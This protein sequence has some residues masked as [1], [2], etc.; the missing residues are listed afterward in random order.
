M[1]L[2]ASSSLISIITIL[3][4]ITISAQAF[5]PSQTTTIQPTT[6]TLSA[7]PTTTTATSGTSK[8]AHIS[9]TTTTNL[10]TVTVYGNPPAALYTGSAGHNHPDIGFG[11]G[12]VMMSVCV[13]L[14]LGVL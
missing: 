9:T 13:G 8:A 3:L 10:A 5:T 1:V 2:L 6:R 14:I 12:G 4:A 11:L 7:S